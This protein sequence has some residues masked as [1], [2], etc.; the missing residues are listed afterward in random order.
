MSAREEHEILPHFEISCEPCARADGS[1][2]RASHL[3][4]MRVELGGV[5]IAYRWV[6]LCPRCRAGTPIT[7]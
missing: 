2:A 4:R 6:P 7:A 1:G 3:V 5:P